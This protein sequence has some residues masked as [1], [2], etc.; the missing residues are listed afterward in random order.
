MRNTG[1][2]GEDGEENA[3]YRRGGG[4]EN[5][6]EDGKGCGTQEGVEEAKTG[7]VGSEEESG[8]GE[9]RGVYIPH[10]CG[11]AVTVG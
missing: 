9:G 7:G 5:K 10:S 6:R 11:S 1:G 2:D 3:K 8:S 4:R